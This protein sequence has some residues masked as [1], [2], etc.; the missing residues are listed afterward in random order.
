ML[1]LLLPAL[2][3]GYVALSA[4]FTAAVWQAS[5][6]AKWL[7]LAALAAS[8]P[9]FFWLGSFAEQFGAGQCYS[10]AMSMIASAVEHTNE[11]AELAKQLRKLPLH[12]YETSCS[13]VEAAAKGLPNANAP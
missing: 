8:A 5:A 4:L 6:R 12:G 9:L 7:G 10:N 11:P 2:L 3:I 1:V 13:E